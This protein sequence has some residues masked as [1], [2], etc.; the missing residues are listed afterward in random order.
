MLLLFLFI[1]IVK[2]NEYEIITLNFQGTKFETTRQTLYNIPYFK[3]LS[4][5]L[6]DSD[7][8]FMDRPAHIFKHILAW[9]VDKN[10]PFPYKY[11]Y[12]LDFFQIDIKN[13]NYDHESFSN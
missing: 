6:E 3:S 1:F 5:G 8:F 2:A 7:V 4:W 10:Y 9:T 13:V 12:E 11:K